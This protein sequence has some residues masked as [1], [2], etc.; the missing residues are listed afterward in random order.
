MKKIL[1]HQLGKPLNAKVSIPGSKSYTGRGLIAAAL[2]NG[3]SI[4]THVS[5]SNDSR[6]LIAALEQ[7]GVGIEINGSTVTVTGF[8]QKLPSLTAHINVGPAGAPSRFLIA[9]C[10]TLPH[11]DIT[12][13][14]N[15][16]LNR[17][18]V[19]P[20][21]EALRELG[22][23]ISYEGLEGCTPVRIR[24]GARL[25]G[26]SVELDGSIS[27]QYFSA[28]MLIAPALEQGLT[29]K[30]KNTLTSKSYVD[31]T[32]QTIEHFGAKVKSN[33]TTSYTVTGSYTAQDYT[34]EA[35]GSGAMNL[36][37][38][39]AVA[40]GQL[41]ITN[42]PAHSLQGDMEFIDMLVSMGCR[43]LDTEGVTIVSEESLIGG[44][45]DFILMPDSAMAASVVA[46]F[47]DGTTTLTGLGTLKHKES[48]RLLATAEQLDR[49]GV[50]ATTTDSSITISPSE[51]ADNTHTT[52]PTIATYDDHRIAMAF[53]IA[54]G[55]T[56]I[57]IEDPDVVGK[58]FPEFWDTL[59]SCGFVI[60]EL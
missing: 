29:I 32:A 22:A 56:D 7:L 41:T 19:G 9:L 45:F 34:I 5:D 42:L 11:S 33:N 24:T 13:S 50:K 55:K 49:L 27:S 3:T 47:S 44:N 37:G 10:A 59:K 1:L 48:D 15:D 21:V 16:Q 26:T 18:P 36:L 14:G 40:G 58:S 46:A 12:I 23:D 38:L 8:G 6:S 31:M 43:R 35:D 4:L 51:T 39:C 52:P 28:L 20:L 30:V 54:A 25:I 60:E 2:S 53:A 57:V 17:R